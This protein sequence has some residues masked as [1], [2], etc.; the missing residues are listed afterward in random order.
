M[1]VSRETSL[2]YRLCCG[3]RAAEAVL[4]KSYHFDIRKALDPL[5]PDDFDTIV[6]RLSASMLRASQPTDAAALRKAI[7]GL[8][9]DWPNLTSPQRQKVITASR[10]ALAPVPAKIIPPVTQRLEVSGPLTMKNTRK[11]TRKGLSATLRAQI[12]V[13]L[14]LQDQRILD[15]LISSQALFVKNEYGV[16]SVQ[17]S[18]MS[19]RIVADGLEQGLGRDAI[20]ENLNN[21]LT[22]SLGITRSKSYWN[23]IAGAFTNRA[24]TFSQLSSYDEANIQKFIFE[25]IL[26]E[27]TTNQCAFLHGKTFSVKAGIDRFDKV[28]SAK[29]P[30]DVK[31]L[32]PWIRQG[33]NEDGGLFL[34][35]QSQAGERTFLA[36]VKESRVGTKGEGKFSNAVSNDQLQEMGANTPP[37]HGLCRSTILADV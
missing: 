20:T 6:G 33:R 2:Q 13:D 9:V 16:R 36:N 1:E 5:D 12:G 10:K 19:R 22:K 34:F 26:D 23:V 14:A 3:A 30:E 25:A 18:D 24:R 32:Q 17:F 29:D 15:N 35:T 7:N 27:V 37:L 11:N 8:D 4:L 31:D 28:E 21:R